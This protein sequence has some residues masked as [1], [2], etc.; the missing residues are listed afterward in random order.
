MSQRT[1]WTAQYTFSGGVVSSAGRARNLAWSEAAVDEY[2]PPRHAPFDTPFDTLFDIR[3]GRVA[4]R[5]IRAACGA[6]QT[7]APLR[8]RVDS[9]GAAAYPSEDLSRPFPPPSN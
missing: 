5:I 6:S 7:F 8:A 1:N 3:A 2:P 9:G 4:R